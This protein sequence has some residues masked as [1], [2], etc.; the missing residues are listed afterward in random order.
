MKKIIKVL[1]ATMLAL[2]VALSLVA[3]GDQSGKAG[4]KGLLLKKYAG[5]DFYTVYGYVD[6]GLGKTTLDI[7]AV[8]GEKEVGRIALNAFDGNDTLVEIVVPDTVTEI[9]AGAFAKMKKLKKITLPFV[10]MTPVADSYQ[11]QKDEAAD[12][13]VDAKRNF[14]YIFGT[15]EYS[16]G[17]QITA[18]YG[19]G[20]ATYYIP[21]NLEEV[22][23]APKGEYNIP[24]YAFSGLGLVEKITLSGN[25]T[26]IG[27]Y[28]FQN[29]RDLVSVNIP[30]TVKTI[31]KGA[32]V[33][34]EMLDDGFT[35]DANSTL[36]EIKEN[37][38]DGS[39]IA[40]IVIPAS[41]KKIGNYCFANAELNKITLAGALE[42]VGAYAFYNC[43]NLKV[44]DVSQVTGT[45]T[46]G[47]WAFRDCDK[48]DW[49][50]DLVN[51]WGARA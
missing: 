10:G 15:E 50:Q 13:S 36:V 48:L 43:A 22:V 18:G 21:S 47:V 46:L 12:K 6:E 49:S 20:T 16:Y 32:F 28:A 14:A 31:Y 34:C 27:E 40:E 7:G 30:Q 5:E 9:Q 41:V 2:T 25:I 26:E 4:D 11:N 24:M 17:E 23:I 45:P 33:G 1:I 42:S 19:S 44:L 29:C 39:K 38:F 51:L 3:C 8:A 37:A 35:F